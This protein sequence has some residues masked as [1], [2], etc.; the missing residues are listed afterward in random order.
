VSHDEL[1][2]RGTFTARCF[3][4]GELLW[5]ALAP[6]MVVTVGKNLILDQALTSGATTMYLG[7]IS[8]TGW[9]GVAATDTMASHPG[10][11]EAGTTYAPT[12]SGGR[13]PISFQPAAS[14]SKTIASNPN[15]TM[16][17]SGMLTGAFVVAGAGA[18]TTVMSTTGVLMSAGQFTGGNYAVLPANIIAI[19]YSIALF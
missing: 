2:I 11:N 3:Q 4:D 12:Y 15:F 19:G 13:Q 1:R 17:S 6:N 16:G 7:L 5:E 10:W 18:S 14:G 8:N 9:T